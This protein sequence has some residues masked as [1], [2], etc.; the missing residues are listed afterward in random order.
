MSNESIDA[1]RLEAAV[2]K[3]IMENNAELSYASKGWMNG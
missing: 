1:R 2:V 3:L